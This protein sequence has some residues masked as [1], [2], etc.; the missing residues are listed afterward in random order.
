MTLIPDLRGHGESQLRSDFG[1]RERLDT[2]RAIDYLISRNDVESSKITLMGSSFG[3]MNA[4]I[5]GAIDSR[6]NTVVSSS[7]PSNLSRWLA[8]QDWDGEERHSFVQHTP[9]D[10]EN[11]EE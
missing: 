11:I 5:A 8:N 2:T 10:F 3:G 9:I 7:S 6:V 1:G 4:I